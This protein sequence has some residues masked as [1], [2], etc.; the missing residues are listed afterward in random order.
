MIKAFWLMIPA[1]LSNPFAAVFGGGKP[2]DGGRTYKDGRRILGDGK[3][4]RGLFSG[5]FCGFLAGCVEVWLSFRGF[6]ILGIEMPG[7]GPDY[8]SSLIVVLAL[9]SGALFGDMFKSFFKRRMGLKRGASL[10]L[11][12]QLDFVVGAWVF[13][14]LAAPEWFVSN[15]TPGIMLTVIIITPLLHLTTNIIGYFIGVKKEP[16]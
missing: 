11:V 13:T 6:E 4:Y 5:I 10:P 12:D 16:W 3:T 14:Y 15:F 7:F 8:T 9:A 2:I 1:Y